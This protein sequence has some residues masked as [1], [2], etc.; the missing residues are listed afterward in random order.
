MRHLPVSRLL[1]LAA[2]SAVVVVCA[3]SGA[4]G[5]AP[6]EAVL[7]QATGDLQV[8]NS[9]D[10]HAIFQAT[11][12]APGRSATGTVKL[13]NSGSLPGDLGLEQLDLQ[14]QPGAAGGRL[15][16][17][18]SL[19]ITDV[20]GGNSVPIFTGRL[21]GLGSR[22]LGSIGP[23]ETR[24]FKFAASLPDAGR[25]PT[26]T[27]GDNAYAGSGLTVRYAWTATAIGPG[28][29][30]SGGPDPVVTIRVRSKKLLTRG[31]LDVMTTCDVACRVSAY[32]SLPKGKRARRATKTKRRTATLTTPNRPARI[33]LKLGRKAKRQLL[34]TLK[35]KRRVKVRVTVGVSAASGGTVTTYT[36]SAS[37]K[38]Q[39]ATR[40]R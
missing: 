14:D 26:A 19:D 3:G 30:A 8:T 38:R 28:P 13:L 2:T 5:P 39:K 33:R 16:D 6:P 35:Q 32:A 22:P 36:R 12:L 21:G 7:T 34:K 17:A 18:I 29:G 4:A 31:F 25:P 15:S 10:G 9:H 37:V 23:G 1:L 40:R 20:S 11:G 24:T 27:G